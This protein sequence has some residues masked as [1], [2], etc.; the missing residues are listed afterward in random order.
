MFSFLQMYL[1]YHY[2]QQMQTSARQFLSTAN[3]YVTL[4]LLDLGRSM[5]Q[6]LWNTEVTGAI[7]VPET[8]SYNR[9]VEIVKLLDTFR[10]DSPLVDS[11]YLLT[12]ASDLTYDFDGNI[13]AIK[14][15]P[16]LSYL[17]EYSA[18]A[19]M[20]ILYGDAF[21]T[22]VIT[23]DGRVAILQDFP[24]PEKNGALLAVVNTD[25]LFRFL[26]GSIDQVTEYLEIRDQSGTLIHAE[27]DPR[28]TVSPHTVQLIGDTGWEITLWQDPNLLRLEMSDVLQLIG[29][30]AIIFGT[31]SVLSAVF[32]TL[33]IYRPIRRLRAIVDEEAPHQSEDELT[34]VERVYQNSLEQRRALFQEIDSMAPIARER[35]YKNLLKGYHFSDAYL[36]DRL[37]Y[38][39]SPLRMEESYFVLICALQEEH[40]STADQRMGLLYQRLTSEKKCGLEASYEFVLMDDYSLVLIIPA[41]KQSEVRFKTEKQAIF[42]QIENLLRDTGEMP[43]LL[44]GNGRVYRGVK[45]LARSYEDA[46]QQLYYLQYHGEAA[47]LPEYSYDAADIFEQTANGNRQQAEKEFEALL[48]QLHARHWDRGAVETCYTGVMNDMVERLIG[49]H[50]TQEELSFFEDYYQNASVASSEELERL[51][52]DTGGQGLTLLYHHGQKSKN[53][54]IS[55]AKKYIVAHFSDSQLSLD[56]VA[57]H[58]GINSA[59]LSRLFFEL[60]EVNFVNFVNGLRVEKAKNLLLQS[61]IPV[62]EVGFKT[63]FNSLQNFNRVFKR[64][65]GTTPGAYRKEAGDKRV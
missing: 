16:V 43:V 32:I 29:I 11:V 38:L 39:K 10:Q 63:G 22:Q 51:V 41:R 65:T 20:L 57:E 46:L 55:Q 30:W 35:L 21:E 8:V 40:D 61:S 49:L 42:R 9:K 14:D 48:I 19:Q 64:H 34:T 47:Q 33:N 26:E 2:K 50:V 18:R 5:Q 23:A 6:Q 28:Q 4:A 25:N 27:G 56:T 15:A 24:T 54:Y 17:S 53:R 36:E 62:T 45:N 7:L 12:Y 44:M 13:I 37:A 3:E 58:I 59:Y 60:S 1:S 31:I 52:R